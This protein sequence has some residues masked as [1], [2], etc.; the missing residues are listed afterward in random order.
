MCFLISLLRLKVCNTVCRGARIYRCHAPAFVR[1]YHVKLRFDIVSICWLIL[2]S[3]TYMHICIYNIH[4]CITYR[5][6]CLVC[7]LSCNTYDHIHTLLY[8]MLRYLRLRLLLLFFLS[9]CAFF[10]PLKHPCANTKLFPWC[11]ASV[12][13]PNLARLL[14]SSRLRITLD[15]RERCLDV[16]NLIINAARFSQR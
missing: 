4:I 1:S 3:Y 16:N 10:F 6:A 15:S 8:I 14:P 9:L 11:F 2:S 13:Y 5:C 7:S 12:K